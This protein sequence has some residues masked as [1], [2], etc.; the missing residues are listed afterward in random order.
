[1][2]TLKEL[3][4]DAIIAALELTNG[5]RTRAAKLLGISIRTMRNKIREYGLAEKGGAN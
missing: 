3:Q 2:K 5:N 1:M 4:R